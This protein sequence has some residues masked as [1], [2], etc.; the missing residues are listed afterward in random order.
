[1]VVL[2][3]YIEMTFLSWSRVVLD[4]CWTHMSCVFLRNYVSL[5]LVCIYMSMFVQHRWWWYAWWRK[6]DSRC[7]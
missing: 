3:L 6:E 7:L 2:M 4:T 1:M 5:C